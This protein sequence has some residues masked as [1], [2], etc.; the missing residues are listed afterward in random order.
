MKTSWIETRDGRLVFF[1]IGLCQQAAGTHTLAPSVDS[2]CALAV[3]A[4]LAEI[5]HVAGDA[6]LTEGTRDLFTGVEEEDALSAPKTIGQ[7]ISVF[8]YRVAQA[9]ASADEKVDT[10]SEDEATLA[11]EIK[12]TTRLDGGS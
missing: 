9:P 7:L 3:L 11:D 8:N 6:T 1:D 10:K 2:H 12:E 5:K 4:V